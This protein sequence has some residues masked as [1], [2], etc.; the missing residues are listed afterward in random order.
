MGIVAMRTAGW[1]P[2][3]LLER[4]GEIDRL[5]E[6][7]GAAAAGS[8]GV[9]V[10]EGPS[11]I[12]KSRLLAE[13]AATARGRGFRVLH[14]AGGEFEREYAAGTVLD[15]FE[16]LLSSAGEK[17]RGRLLGGA[18]QAASSVFD[19][20]GIGV[21]AGSL[22]APERFA[23][24][25]G[26][27]WLLVNL[28]E[29]SPVAVV[30]DD[31]HWVDELSLQFLSYV[32]ARLG[33]LPVALVVA[34][35][36]GD[37]IDNDDL[38]G[39]LYETAQTQVLRPRSLSAAAVAALVAST[40]PS[41][42]VTG[43][44]VTSVMTST[45]GNPF[46]VRQLTAAV[47]DRPGGWQVVVDDPA[48]FAPSAV[49]R[50][51]MVRLRRFGGGA[52]AL[53]RAASVLG[54]GASLTIVARLAQLDVAETLSTAEDLRT[55]EILCSVDPVAF[56]HPIVRAAVYSEIPAG[57]RPGLHKAAAAILHDTAAAPDAIA[58]HLASAP[59][60]SEQWVR[61]ALH[62]GGRL[63][64][65]RGSP[66]AAIRYLRRALELWPPAESSAQIS[67]DLA[68]SEAA[69]G[70]PTSVARFV[71]ALS[72]IQDVAARA[73]PLY[74]LGHTLY[75][76]GRHR[77]AAETFREGAEM[78]AETTS[79]QALWFESAYASCAHYLPAFRP[80][81]ML[82]LESVAAASVDR[83]PGTPAERAVHGV[84]AL[85]RAASVPSPANGELARR[86]L[87]GAF[88][89]ANGILGSVEVNLAMTALI[90]SGEPEAALGH[91][92]AVLHDARERGDALAHTEGFFIRALALYRL[93]RIDEAAAD[94]QMAVEGTRHGWAATLPGPH[95]VLADCLL[96][97]GNFA[98]A[99]RIVDEAATLV[100][101]GESCPSAAW[102][103]WSRG[104][105]RL[106]TGDAQGALADLL[107]AG[108]VL[109]T[110]G[111]RSP[112]VFAWRSAAAAAALAAG[113]TELVDKLL[114]AELELSAQF[115]LPEPAAAA[116]RVRA[117]GENHDAAVATLEKAA[118]GLGDRP[119]LVLCGVL[120]DLGARRR[121]AGRPVD[122]RNDLRLA[123]EM[124]HR[125]GASA[126]AEQARNEL[127]A[128]GARPRRD[129]ITGAD[130]LTSSE[131]RIARLA[132]DGLTNRR[133]AESLFLTKN[134][135]EWHLRNVYRKLGI[136]SRQDLHDS[137][138]GGDI[139]DSADLEANFAALSAELGFASA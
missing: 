39:R 5:T 49:A 8:G 6:Q 10:I 42:G 61:D 75:R 43:E 13:A 26:L 52:L 23:L 127:L 83:A 125:L 89:P 128:S 19:G 67:V 68:L 17:D 18:A 130:A 15:L 65:R 136:T 53:A 41:D 60:S 115:G 77:E 132:A 79:E 102:L 106:H 25:H 92:S 35:R 99:Q 116:L 97:Q 103:F 101:G 7:L 20:A 118:A 87:A 69:A 76:R 109:E 16:P 104:R 30:V 138:A 82:R 80:E 73:E 58:R 46:L 84:L 131:Q 56:F 112:G 59:P 3:L 126:L 32:A 95:G 133:V 22:P 71:D 63:A 93:G 24:L 91:L 122:A 47:A 66:A 81:A 48:A 2:A 11:G 34:L 119:S 9:C 96:A 108:H 90:W 27:Y 4:E 64:A 117:A 70:E 45:R 37:P 78:F 111:I 139:V 113:D 33:D 114:L 74:A 28:A 123:L 134:T 98:G 120:V 85:Y 12:G 55:V 62:D 100:Q 135:V 72:L 54:D 51:V 14:A 57:H 29:D 40:G 1:G 36:T 31:A 129:R 38:V 86:A 107:R 121:R 110:A 105:V 94:A 44:V 21:V 124:A 137:L 50:N 88:L